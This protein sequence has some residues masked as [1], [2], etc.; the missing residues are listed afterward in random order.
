MQVKE[1]VITEK[2]LRSLMAE[3]GIKSIYQL[4]KMTGIATSN[5][6]PAFN[7]K[8]VLSANNWEKIKQVL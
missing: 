1:T 5:L 8:V 2:D 6:Y 7:N 3:R 4:G